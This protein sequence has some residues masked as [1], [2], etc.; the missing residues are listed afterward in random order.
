[1]YKEQFIECLSFDMEKTLQRPRIPTNVMFYK[2]QLWLYNCGIHAGKGNK[3][4]C[5]VWFGQGA[6]EVK[7]CLLHHIER[8]IEKDTQEQ[9]ILWSDSCGGQNRNIKFTL[10]LKAALESHPSLKII[11]MRFL[12]SGR[13]FL[14]NDADFSDIETALKHQQ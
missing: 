6:Q 13:I 9:L 10:M 4:Y 11:H 8:N 3:G 5:Y 2:R 7:S 14:P 12:V 1:M